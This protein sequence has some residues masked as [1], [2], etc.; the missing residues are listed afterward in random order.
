[1]LASMRWLQQY[2]EIP[3]TP[4]ELADRL[5]RVGLE[6]EQVI[7]LGEGLDGVVT[8]K[9]VKVEKHPQSDHLLICQVDVG[10][11]KPLQILT[12]APNVHENDIVPV[13]LV[14]AHLP[15]GKVIQ[16][17]KMAGYDSAGM[18]CSAEELGID[19][20]LLLPEQRNGLYILPDTTPLGVDAKAYLGLDDVVL[21]IDLTAN[22][23]DC[24]N[25]LGLAREIGAVLHQDVRLP[26]LS[27]Q[28]TAGSSATDMAK[29]EIQCPDLCSRFA[30]RLV[31][32]V[33][34][35]ASPEWMQ[36]VLRA[37][38]IRPI[39]NVVDVTN[40]VMMELGQPMHAYDYDK[41]QD[42]TWIVRRA[43][44]GEQLV[45]LDNQKRD[46][47]QDMIV[48]A[49]PEKPIGLAGVM[50]G[51]ATEVTEQTVNVMLESATFYG[52]SIR[53]TSKDLGLRS[54]ASQRFERG[55]DTIR[56]QD[57]LDRAIHLL[58]KIGSCE[59]VPGVVEDYP[60][61]Q[62]P[63]EIQA[64]PD[65]LRRR[66]GTEEISDATMRNILEDLHFTVQAQ[67]DRS[68]LVTVPTWR[69]DCTCDADLAEEVARIYGYDK[70]PSSLPQL[71][72]AR[73]GQNP[74][75]DVKDSIRD[76]L[77][78]TGLDEAITY[79][80]INAGD[81]DQLSLNA[82]DPRRQS[83]QIINP[84]SD[85]FK[86][87]RTTLVPSLLHTAAYNLARQS[88]R[89]AIFEV[90]RVFLP[91]ALPLTAQPAE[92]T[93]LG[94]VLSGKR[95]A[96]NWTEA[97]DLFDFYDLKGILEG[98][99]DRLHVTGMEYKACQEK[100]L[101]PGK[102]CT[103]VYQGRPVGFM[104]ALHPQVQGRFGLAN[105]TFVLEMD[106]T[107]F[108]DEAEKIVQFTHIP[109]FPSSSRDIAVVVPE[110]V[111]A[112]DLM[113]EIRQQGGQL[114]KEIHLFDVYTGRQI[115][116]GYKSVAFTLSFQDLSRTLKDKEVDDT[117]RQMVK[118]V[119]EKFQ[120]ALRE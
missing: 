111:P 15:G 76:Y 2:V 82:E 99:L 28:D 83:I 63:V 90:G 74:L 110:S 98:L 12:G 53:H 3:M 20:K 118:H 106:V 65:N 112:S 21:D 36:R 115:Q 35:T 31:K 104:G 48:I 117:V 116:S 78:D 97:K 19:A 75:E 50:G 61:E 16:D 52:P 88:D 101:H 33:K 29:V 23:S 9:L 51:L 91:K 39:N 85:D 113:E 8:G 70:I 25:M 38:N 26:K 54:E 73:G 93:R 1:M 84:I 4:E 86:T 58:Q 105:E 24:F 49:D 71:D 40:Y 80:F 41:V 22:R 5:T 42:H 11:E 64:L 67:P 87:M 14:G 13:A 60:V 68:W 114:L 120:A 45:T 44:A 66:I 62:K 34:I 102:S 89:V 6:V 17:V 46:L 55:V 79:T 32:N 81:Y 108:V 56:T 18:C 77:A 30:L 43:A 69:N 59:A 95:N 103:L 92:V 47:T 37:V 100:F 27:T 96:S 57:A 107:S 72:M 119:Q 7:H 94:I 109:Q 10:E